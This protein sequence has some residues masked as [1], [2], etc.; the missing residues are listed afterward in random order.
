MHTK[1]ED[2]SILD[3][4]FY[5]DIHIAA[6]LGVSIGRLRNKLSAGHPLPPRIQPPACRHRLWPRQ[7]VHD[8]L[9]QFVVGADAWPQRR[10]STKSQ[11]AD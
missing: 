6:L 10:R 2:H 11:P 4:A 3:G 8:W 7:A 9:D 1:I 5:T